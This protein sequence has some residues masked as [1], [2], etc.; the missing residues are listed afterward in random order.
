MWCGTDTP[1]TWHAWSDPRMP[2]VRAA[3]AVPPARAPPINSSPTSTCSTISPSRAACGSTWSRKSGGQPRLQKRGPKRQRGRPR[4]P[5]ASG[6]GSRPHAPVCILI[7]ARVAER[8]GRGSS[9]SSR[10]WL[11]WAWLR[12]L[13]TPCRPRRPSPAG[14]P[15]EA[16]PAYAHGGWRRGIVE[17]APGLAAVFV[18]SAL[19]RRRAFGAGDQR[20]A[21]S[22]KGMVLSVH[23]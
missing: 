2:I 8:W 9:H 14:K 7:R 20:P 5:S 1:A 17:P 16:L 3:T 4:C 13:R 6:P 19:L 12:Q 18:Q 11:R 23:A 10:W 21:G 15:A 22:A